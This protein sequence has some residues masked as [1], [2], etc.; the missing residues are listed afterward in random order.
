MTTTIHEIKGVMEA[1]I[2][3]NDIKQRYN[4]LRPSD[5]YMRQ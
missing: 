4:S 1:A 5:G 3:D 2:I